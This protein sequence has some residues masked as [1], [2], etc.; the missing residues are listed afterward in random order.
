MKTFSQAFLL[1]FFR[2]VLSSPLLSF[3]RD[4]LLVNLNGTKKKLTELNTLLYPNLFRKLR[5]CSP[6]IAAVYTLE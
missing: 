5:M 1:L 3:Y 2:A 4:P 6:H